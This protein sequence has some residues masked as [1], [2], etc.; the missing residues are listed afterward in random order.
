[1]K[2]VYLCGSM[3]GLKSF[4]AAWRADMVKWFAQYGIKCYNPC[5]EEI[6]L[7]KRYKVPPAA[8]QHW[9]KLPQ[10][11]QEKIIKQ[12]ASQ[13]R[14][15]KYLV[16]YFTKY[17]SGTSFEVVYAALLGIPVYFITPLRNIRKW[18]GTIAR[19]ERNKYFNNFQQLKQ[20]LVYKY[21]LRKKKKYGRA[22]AD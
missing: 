12:D 18:P 3:S 1:M 15:S 6:K 21:T 16:C 2:S 7:H 4:G 5:T 13:V 11:L 14:K 20:F 22:R 10:I 8:K 9:D 17:S 19:M